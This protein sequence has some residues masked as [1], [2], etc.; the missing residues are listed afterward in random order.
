MEIAIGYPFHLTMESYETI[1]AMDR[2]LLLTKS[3]IEVYI[4]T[5]VILSI[6]RSAPKKT[7]IENERIPIMSTG[8]RILIVGTS[9]SG[10][11]TLAGE[12]AK[13]LDVPHFEFDAYRHG[14]N[15]L[16]TPDTVFRQNLAAALAGETW[17][18]DG[19]YSVAR[20]V[21]WPRATVVIWLDY[22]I[23]VVLGRLL[24]RT[25]LRWVRREELWNGNRENIFTVT[26][27]LIWALKTHWSRR[28][29][30][31]ATFQLSQYSH[32]E[33][34]R[35]RS[36]RSAREWVATFQERNYA[37]ATLDADKAVSNAD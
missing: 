13:I 23:G 4:P 18:A 11:T 26:S 32:L 21:V 1:L 14:P 3:T 5:P 20:D 31:P 8:V 33:V 36:P 35:L 22:W 37:E 29:T 34:V 17:V 24:K 7:S 16:E 25:I 2:T 6:P 12:M 19:N 30:M 10:K 27:L 9:G 15:W 28:S